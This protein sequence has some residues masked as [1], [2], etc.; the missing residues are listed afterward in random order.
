LRTPFLE[1]FSKLPFYVSYRKEEKPP[2]E[3]SGENT[4][5]QTSKE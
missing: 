1:N 4:E 2:V 5:N 3:E